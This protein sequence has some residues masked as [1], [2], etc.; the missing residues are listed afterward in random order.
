MAISGRR[1]ARKL[2]AIVAPCGKPRMIVS[3]H[4]NELTCNAMLAWS[5][6]TAI[7]WYLIAPGKLMQNASLKASKAGCLTICSTR[8]CSSIVSVA[9]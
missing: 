7:D 1:V 4:G 6:D 9:L 8:L 2:T 5:K 3:D